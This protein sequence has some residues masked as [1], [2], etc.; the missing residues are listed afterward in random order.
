M[1]QF[2]KN[3]LVRNST[4]VLKRVV[5]GELTVDSGL[6]FFCDPCYLGSSEDDSRFSYADICSTVDAGECQLSVKDKVIGAVVVPTVYGDGLYPVYGLFDGDVCV[7]VE[8]DLVSEMGKL[9]VEMAAKMK[10][11]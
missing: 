2:E 4:A 6:L 1:N 11:P 8:I 9:M 10:K 7:K 3:K 5:I